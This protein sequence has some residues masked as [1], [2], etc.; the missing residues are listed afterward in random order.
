MMYSA[1]FYVF[2]FIFFLKT[3]YYSFVYIFDELRLYMESEL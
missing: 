1:I 3:T 2:Q